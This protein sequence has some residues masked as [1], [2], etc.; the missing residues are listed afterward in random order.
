MSNTRLIYCSKETAEV[1]NDD[2]GSFINDVDNGIVV[3]VGDEISIEAIAINSV[4]VGAEIIEIPKQ[5]KN[6]KY[7]TN[8]MSLDCAFYIHHNRHPYTILMPIAGMNTIETDKTLATYGYMKNGGNFPPPVPFSGT[9]NKYGD[10]VAINLNHRFYLGSYIFNTNQDPNKPTPNP[11]GGANA[12]DAVPSIGVF[13][14]SRTNMIFEVDTGYDNPANIANKITQ[15]FHAG[16]IT[17]NLSIF[18]DNGGALTPYATFN[19]A[20]TQQQDLG[21]WTENTCVISVNANPIANNSTTQYSPYQST[22][23]YQNPFYAYYG[24]RLLC[25]SVGLGGSGVKNN[26]WLT[27]NKTGAGDAFSNS[28]YSLDTLDNSGG[29]TNVPV[30][31]IL[32]TNLPYT[33]ANCKLVRDFIHSQKQFPVEG[34]TTTDGLNNN[35]LIREITYSLINWGRGD[36]SV[37]DRSAWKPIECPIL[38]AGDE[39][40]SEQVEIATFFDPK[41][42]GKFRIQD[43]R[44]GEFSIAYDY[45]VVS[46]TGYSY[47]ALLLSKFLDFMIVPIYTGT[48]N[49]QKEYNIGLVMNSFVK[50]GELFK[51]CDYCMIDL[52][53]MNTLN[54]CILVNAD[55][56][57]KGAPSPPTQA[58]DYVNC[59]QVGAPNVN[60][61]FDETRGRFALQNMSWNYMI[62]NPTSGT[63]P[64]ASAG[65]EAIAVNYDFGTD[66]QYTQGGSTQFRN[67]Y[68]QSGIGILDISV[69]DDD[70]NRYTIDYYDEADIKDKWNN[71]LLARMGFSY[72]QLTNRNGRPDAV[73]TQRTYESNKPV[74]GV[75]MFPY[76]LTCNLRFDT[77]IDEG[78]SNNGTG[79]LPMFDLSPSAGFN[80]NL[81]SSSDLIFA[82]GLPKKLEN[83][84]WLIK[85]DIIDGVEFNSEKTGGGRQNILAVCN[86]A[87]LAGDFAFS[88]STSYA[89][90][91]T[92]EFVIS[93]VKT[94]ILNPDLTPADINDATTI[95]YKVVSPIPF[96]QQQEEAELEAKKK[97]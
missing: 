42:W 40:L 69:L 66:Y 34:F 43:A 8:A 25:D 57:N 70:Y 32:T 38:T 88:F 53:F 84:F 23:A 63:Q 37:A 97:K 60:M 30:N 55:V 86:R 89:F 67:K 87:Y 27:A 68:A 93:G 44:A 80:V 77:S 54:P 7:K 36:D 31:S 9:K 92:K 2:E 10:N 72:K 21:I 75:S 85:S 59:I 18:D 52:S 19:I 73:F 65:Q 28:I 79:G 13:E 41:R 11:T 82:K 12:D 81:S 76:P 90:K 6:Y 78:L 45:E 39:N 48:F 4:G 15:D 5:I 24:S 95:I 35:A 49:N 58:G 33:F 91:A 62:Q 14:F 96:F 61:L 94:A 83:P 3:K 20:G 22:L 56:L 74:R 51:A 26:G 1:S 64:N 46:P 17:P 16:N 71:S 50:N 29:N 47:N